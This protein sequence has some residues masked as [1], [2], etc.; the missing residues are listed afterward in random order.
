MK[1]PA[2]LGHQRSLIGGRAERMANRISETATST[3]TTPHTEPEVEAAISSAEGQFDRE[4]AI[5]ERAYAIWEEEGRPE[6]Q[7]LNHWFRAEAEIDYAA[8]HGEG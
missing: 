1:E 6:G 4:Q 7:H 3:A 2:Y 5:R 8:Q